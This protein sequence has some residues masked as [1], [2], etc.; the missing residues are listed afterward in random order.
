MLTGF[1]EMDTG[2]RDLEF[3]FSLFFLFSSFLFSSLLIEI[4]NGLH[5]SED[6]SQAN[7]EPVTSIL[8]AF[9]GKDS[10]KN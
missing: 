1:L 3:F 4:E 6:Q 10:K 7:V 5:M 2:K 9:L 8:P